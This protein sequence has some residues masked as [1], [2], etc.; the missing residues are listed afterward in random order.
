MNFAVDL[1]FEIV[2]ERLER[3][4]IKALLIGGHAVNCYGVTR[5]TQ[6]VDFM[7][8]ADDEGTILPIM[9]DAGFTN[10]SKHENVTFFSRPGDPFRVDFLKVDRATMNG[11]LANA[12]EIAYFGERRI[13]VPHLKDLLGMKVFALANGG[14][15]REAKDFWDIVNLV[16]ENR[17]DVETGLKALC[18][19]YGT[20]GLF[21]RLR[22]QIERLAHA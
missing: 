3:A 16:I 12:Q 4:H 6:D 10:I 8:A 7:I 1:I 21:E 18:T 11:L 19:Q 2:G 9:R 13:R 20:D 5:A 17:F 14:A 22:S 15:K